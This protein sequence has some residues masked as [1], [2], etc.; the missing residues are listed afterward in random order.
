ML[1]YF[2]SVL[3]S[4]SA[5]TGGLKDPRQRGELLYQAVTIAAMLIVLVSIWVF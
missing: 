3:A 1:S 2:Q 4:N 5:E